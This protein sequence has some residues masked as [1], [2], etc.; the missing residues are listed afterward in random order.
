MRILLTCALLLWTG[1]TYPLGYY[2]PGP[3]PTD[4][5]A[6]QDQASAAVDS[7]GRHVGNF[8]LALTLIGI[9]GAYLWERDTQRSVWAECM[10]AKGYEVQEIGDNAPGFQRSD[11]YWALD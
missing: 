7:T 8:L 11:A 6:C 10:R 4:N 5:L 9:P 1:C 3:A 2:R